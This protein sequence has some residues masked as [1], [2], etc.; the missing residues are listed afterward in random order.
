VEYFARDK[1]KAEEKV[2][3]VSA[4]LGI[5]LA[6]VKIIPQPIGTFYDFL[7]DFNGSL[8]GTHKHR[9]VGIV[10]IGMHTTDFLLIKNLK[11]NLERASGSL[12]GGVY[13]II[14]AVRR[15]ILGKFDRDTVTMKEAE[16]CVLKRKPIKIKGVDMEV[17]D[18]VN[19]HISA[20]A[21]NILGIVKSSWSHEGEPD[22]VLLTGGGSILL[23]SHFSDLAETTQLMEG[24]QL[25]NARGYYKYG[26]IIKMALS[27]T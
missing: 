18:I 22:L 25:A 4:H 15:E 12:T 17:S 27:R 7:V 26:N 1:E 8:T 9:L 3:F 23:R 13:G 5:K 14:E 2:R 20:T 10:D 21:Q 24:A 16:S 6:A 11:D 19:K